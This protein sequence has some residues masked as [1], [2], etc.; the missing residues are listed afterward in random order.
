MRIVSYGP[1]RAERPGIAVPGR[2]IAPLDPLLRSLGYPAIDTNTLL[3]LLDLLRPV[4]A[5]ALDGDGVRWLDE[6]TTRLGPPVPSP[7]KVIVA[8]GNYQSHVDEAAGRKNAP[9]P[10]EPII[11]FKPSNTV[12]GPNDALVRPRQ[13]EQLDYET[14]IGVVIGRGGR[15][16]PAERA[17]D[18]VAGYCIANDVTARDLAFRDVHLSPLFAQMTRAKGIPTGAPLGPW[19]VTKDEIADPHRLELRCWVNGELRQRGSSAEMI[20]DIPHL[21]EDFSKVIELS[22]GDV[23][24]TGTTTGCGAFQDPPVFLE[25][26]DV[27]RMEITGL[28]VMETPVVDET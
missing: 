18:H 13:S 3:G 4:L 9:S 24:M 6:R 26:G 2:G 14:E 21:V 25:A 12:I 15:N 7:E 23:I 17:Y 28:G 20:V 8:G 10:S 5:E 22:P 27:V 11:V 19:L 16:I 1:E